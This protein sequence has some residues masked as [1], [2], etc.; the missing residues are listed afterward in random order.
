MTSY[1][2]P[3]VRMSPDVLYQQSIS[4][5]RTP[6]E[7]PSDSSEIDI[8]R[9]GTRLTGCQIVSDPAITVVANDNTSNLILRTKHPVASGV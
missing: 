7:T 2:H 8:E 4:V 9:L 6:I 3:P 5:F 1:P